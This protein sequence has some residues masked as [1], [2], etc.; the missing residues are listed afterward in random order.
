MMKLFKVSMFNK[1]TNKV[2]ESYIY[3]RN[4]K[5]AVKDLDCFRSNNYHVVDSVLV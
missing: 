5:T 1:L 2:E 3:S 4:A